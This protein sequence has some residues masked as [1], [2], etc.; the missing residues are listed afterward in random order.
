MEQTSYQTRL[1]QHLA[2]YRRT[3]LGVREMGVWRR[4]GKK[5]AHIL[6]ETLKRLNILETVRAEFWTYQTAK[7]V[8]LHEDFHHLNSSQAMCFN[9]LFPLFGWQYRNPTRLFRALNLGDDAVLDWGFEHVVDSTENTRFDFYAKLGSGERLLFETK[10]S[11]NGFGQAKVDSRHLRKLRD[12]YIP[13]LRGKIDP[14]YLE[15]SLFF[16]HYQLLRNIAYA[17]P[18]GRK[19]V[20]LLMPRDN[21]SLQREFTFLKSALSPDM[22]AVVRVVWL[23]DLVRQLKRGVDEPMFAAHLAL[24]E[25][26]YVLG[27]G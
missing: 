1:R 10:L 13:M 2:E 24:F 18:S 23:E 14:S 22:R 15:P 12:I 21:S 17:E 11:E 25:E 26:K 4:N 6:P 8:K 3:R 16:R 27:T 9:L 7:S 20:F 5:Y 19:R